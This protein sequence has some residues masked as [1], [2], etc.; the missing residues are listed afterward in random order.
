MQAKT[1]TDYSKTNGTSWHGDSVSTTVK[2]LTNV[3]GEVERGHY[4]D[5]SQFDWSLEL[6]DG[7]VFTI[8]DW[9]EYRKFRTNERID[10]HIGGYDKRDTLKA[11]RVIEHLL[12]NQS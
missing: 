3:F 8:Y 4:D 12:I 9:K 2:E 10:F 5:K 1:I 7:T 6:S 11:K